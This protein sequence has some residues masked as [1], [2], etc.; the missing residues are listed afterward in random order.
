MEV[1]G[2][3]EEEEVRQGTVEITGLMVVG[4]GGEEEEAVMVVLASSS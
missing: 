3:G 4:G 1:V 2:D